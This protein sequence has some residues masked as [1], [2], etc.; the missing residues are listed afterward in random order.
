[1][2]PSFEIAPKVPTQC[3]C[4]F[5]F[6]FVLTARFANAKITCKIY[7]II[8]L[9]FSE[10]SKRAYLSKILRNFEPDHS[11]ASTRARFYETPFKEE[12]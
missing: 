12:G 3:V 10:E 2:N 5:L 8:I 6:Q 7:K 4:D 9:K 1:M 11:L